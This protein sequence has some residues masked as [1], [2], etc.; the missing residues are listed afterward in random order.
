MDLKLTREQTV[1]M[2]FL[3]KIK[4]ARKTK[5][6]SDAHRSQFAANRDSFLEEAED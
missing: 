5:A 3:P 2:K 1:A 4:A 6:K